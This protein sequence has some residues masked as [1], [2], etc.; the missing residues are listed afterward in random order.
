MNWE[1]RRRR[2]QEEQVAARH[3]FLGKGGAG[4]DTPEDRIEAFI[5]RLCAW[6]PSHRERLRELWS[7]GG[8]SK[9]CHQ[10]TPTEWSRMLEYQGG[11]CALAKLGDCLGRLVLDHD[12]RIPFWE[13]LSWRGILC[14]KHNLTVYRRG[15]YEH[16][17]RERGVMDARD[18]LIWE[19]LF[20]HA[21]RDAVGLHLSDWPDPDWYHEHG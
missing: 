8:I 21:D 9:Q 5:N 20:D 11:V 17:L 7:N 13:P 16:V 6:G 4:P 10:C 1:E 12:H 19:Y 18:T 14:S 2:N 3:T 15:E